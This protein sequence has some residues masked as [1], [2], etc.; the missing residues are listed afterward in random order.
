MMGLSIGMPL[1]SE[2]AKSELQVGTWNARSINMGK[3]IMVKVILGILI[4]LRYQGIVMA[5]KWTLS[6]RIS[7]SLPLNI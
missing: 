4:H 1:K 6:I 3:C 7:H 5:W 2:T